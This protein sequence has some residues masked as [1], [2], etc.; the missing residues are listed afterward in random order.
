MET[1]TR[2]VDGVLICMPVGHLYR[3]THAEFLGV[4]NDLARKYGRGKIILNFSDIVSMDVDAM[5]IVVH[6]VQQIKGLG[7]K[8]VLCSL[9]SEILQQFV[10]SKL[11]RYISI[12]ANEA[13]ALAE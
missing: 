8:L 13:E 6:A 9:K 10:V 4:M 1:E 11:N 12:Y 5:G 3:K 7:G 2:V